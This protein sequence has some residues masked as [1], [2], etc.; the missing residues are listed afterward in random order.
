MVDPIDQQLVV[1]TKEAAGT[2]GVYTT[3]ISAPGALQPVTTLSLGLAQL[4]T[5]GDI[6]ASGD[7]IVLRTYTK[8]WVWTRGAGESLATALA[9]PPCSAP[10]P[11][12]AQGEALTLTP[13]GDGYVTGSE[14]ADSPL[15]HVAAGT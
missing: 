13:A 9:R 10:A 7:T 2:S 1:V 8:V 11:T 3:P 15:W 14:G 12:D 6:S 5:A 4:V